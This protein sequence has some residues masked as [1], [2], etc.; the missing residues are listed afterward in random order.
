MPKS[1]GISNGNKKE[2]F[3]MTQLRLHQS[4]SQHFPGAT[5]KPVRI[6]NVQLKLELN[7]N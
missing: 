6:A 4:T 2:G 7:T 3:A 1:V 5:D